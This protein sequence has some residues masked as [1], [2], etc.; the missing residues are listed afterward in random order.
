MN[1]KL[2]ISF[3]ASFGMVALFSWIGYEESIRGGYVLP[4]ANYIVGVIIGFVCW[5]FFY[6]MSEFDEAEKEGRKAHEH[7]LES[8]DKCFAALYEYQ[9][10]LRKKKE[11]ENRNSKNDC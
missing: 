6:A 7:Y 3:I 4:L 1:E 5:G 2:I 9:E 8:R 10:M 11:L